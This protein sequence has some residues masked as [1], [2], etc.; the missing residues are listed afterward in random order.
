MYSKSILF[1]TC[2]FTENW[3]HVWERCCVWSEVC[4]IYTVSQKTLCIWLAITVTYTIRC[5][6]LFGRNVTDEVSNQNFH[7]SPNQCIRTTWKNVK[8]HNCYIFNEITVYCI[9]NRHTKHTQII[10]WSELNQPSFAQW[11]NYCNRLDLRREHG[12]LSPVAYK[13][14]GHTSALEYADI[15]GTC[16]KTLFQSSNLLSKLEA[17]CTHKSAMTHAG[18]FFVPRDL[19]LLTPRTAHG[20]SLCKVWWS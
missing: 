17:A 2:D 14:R 19:D 6:W 8:P 7:T 20:P 9:A 5:R 11:S 10:T 1:F 15:N 18:V 3:S 13:T 4:S 12:I 16:K